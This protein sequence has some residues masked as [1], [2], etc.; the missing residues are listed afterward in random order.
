VEPEA[1]AA[2]VEA[3]EFLRAALA[4]GPRPAREV[5]AEGSAAGITPRTLRRAR[6]ASGV[7]ARRVAEPGAARGTG[8]WEWVLEVAHEPDATSTDENSGPLDD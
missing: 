5:L 8:R 7:E 4:A 3:A 1:R 6:Q 2:R